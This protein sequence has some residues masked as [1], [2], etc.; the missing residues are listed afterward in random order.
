MEGGKGQ[1]EGL[2]LFTVAR[3]GRKKTRKPNKRDFCCR[4]FPASWTTL[5]PAGSRPWPWQQALSA[6]MRNSQSCRLTVLQMIPLPLLMKTGKVL[7]K[8]LSGPIISSMRSRWLYAGS[9]SRLC[10]SPRQEQPIGVLQWRMK[11]HVVH[12]LMI[13]QAFV[14]TGNW[15]L[16][17]CSFCI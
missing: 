10:A 13:K 8:H 12:L 4:S 7:S 15:R 6:M 5:L 14:R 16:Y 11:R 2:L 1:P 17:L 9:N 3:A